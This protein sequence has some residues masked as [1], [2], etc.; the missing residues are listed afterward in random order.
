MTDS[1][2][3]PC[4][5]LLYDLGCA[6]AARIELDELI[7]F[8]VVKCREALEAEGASVLLLDRERNEFYFLTFRDR[9][10]PLLSSCRVCGFRLTS[11]SPEQS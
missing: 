3:T 1:E 8:V 2:A 11:E 5:K 4:L 10:Q 7:S 9:I 6:F